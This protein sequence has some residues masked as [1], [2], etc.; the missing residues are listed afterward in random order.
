MDAEEL[1]LKLKDDVE[2]YL[3]SELLDEQDEILA[4][5]CRWIVEGKPQP[6]ALR[7][8]AQRHT[9][10][11]RE[12]REGVTE[13]DPA[14]V[15]LGDSYPVRNAEDVDRILYAPVDTGDG[16]SGWLWFRLANGDLVFGCYPQGTT[17]EECE[18]GYTVD[19]QVAVGDGTIRILEAEYEDVG[20][21]PPR[22]TL[23]LE[24][25][26]DGTYFLGDL[27]AAKAYLRDFYEVRE[28][29]L[30]D[31]VFRVGEWLEGD[32]HPHT[33]G[34]SMKGD[35]E[36]AWRYFAGADFGPIDAEYDEA[37][38][39]ALLRENAPAPPPLDD[40]ALDII[41][42]ALGVLEADTGGTP[43]R[44]KVAD[45]LAQVKGLRPKK[46]FRVIT[47]VTLDEAYPV[48]AADIEGARK[49]F[50]D[51]GYPGEIITIEEES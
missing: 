14:R 11:P 43:Y 30:P 17:Y 33:W 29:R 13:R 4:D 23:L 26:P 34:T 18:D 46:R 1:Y 27:D 15:Y 28:E 8:L 32:D 41:E 7:P 38:L 12:P 37:H 19:W 50:E 47:R 3:G 31:G 42:R 24:E 49:A 35:E 36:E 51:A 45:V 5:A 6:P 2:G 10:A 25:R 44:Q 16:T 48:E 9:V 21:E 20:I 40:H 39:F 22:R